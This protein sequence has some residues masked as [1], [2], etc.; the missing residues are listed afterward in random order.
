[1]KFKNT[2]MADWDFIMEHSSSG[3]LPSSVATRI[4]EVQKRKQ[5]QQ[6]QEKDNG[7]PDSA[8]REQDSADN[9]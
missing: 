6:E 2:R 4:A 9:P 7:E 8:D 5:Q 1:M 3:S